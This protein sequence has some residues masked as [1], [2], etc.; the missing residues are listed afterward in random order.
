MVRL[1]DK[2]RE[3]TIPAVFYGE[4]SNQKVAD[5]VCESTDAEKLIFHSCHNLSAED[6][7]NGE[8]YLSLMKKNANNLK[9]A[10]N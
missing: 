8:T 7:E 4:F 10:L 6:F 3:E 1:I 5:L 2:V 9:E